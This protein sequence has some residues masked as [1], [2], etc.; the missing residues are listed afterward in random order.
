[1]VAIGIKIYVCFYVK[2][3]IFLVSHVMM[4]FST[5]TSDFARTLLFQACSSAAY[6]TMLFVAA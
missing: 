6:K 2:T 3:L 5:L 4:F 1:M